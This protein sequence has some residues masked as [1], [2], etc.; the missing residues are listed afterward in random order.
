MFSCILIFAC[1]GLHFTEHKAELYKVRS[2]LNGCM[3]LS[4]VADFC[5][6]Q[7]EFENIHACLHA[8]LLPKLTKSQ[9]HMEIVLPWLI[10]LENSVVTVSRSPLKGNAFNGHT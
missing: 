10:M 1:F 7:S 5:N 8:H 4:A 3:A 2:W 9:R 6:H